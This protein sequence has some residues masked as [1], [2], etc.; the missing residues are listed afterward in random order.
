M[1]SL[2]P[3]VQVVVKTLQSCTVTLR[4]AFDETI[5]DVKEKVAVAW[6][7]PVK[8]QGLVFAGRK[9]QDEHLLSD[10]NIDSNST[11]LLLLR[12]SDP[13]LR[14]S[15]CIVHAGQPGVVGTITLNDLMVVDMIGTVKSRIRDA[16]GIP[17]HHQK[18]LVFQ[19]R[20]L[21]D[22]HSLLAYSINDEARLYLVVEASYEIW[23][24]TLT[25]IAIKLFVNPNDI[26]KDV[27]D[28]IQRGHFPIP[29]SHQALCYAG[30]ELEDAKCL[31]A[32]GIYARST[33]ILC[34]V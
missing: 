33:L 2:T 11:L 12:L 30:E 34:V 28:M 22:A 24:K 27:K 23:V 26:V 7:I 13:F 3:C 31:S 19:G 25:N 14:L 32:Y 5:A 8:A 20:M 15:V 1:A 21:Q 10:Y 4:V 9:L 18:F 6:G 16:V 29:A 17:I